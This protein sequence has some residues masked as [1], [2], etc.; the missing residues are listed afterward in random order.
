MVFPWGKFHTIPGGQDGAGTQG[1]MKC[2]SFL[3][4]KTFIA[5]FR[6]NPK[7]ELH[8]QCQSRKLQLLWADALF[9]LGNLMQH[10]PLESSAS[11]TVDLSLI[12]ELWG[13]GRSLSFHISHLTKCKVLMQHCGDGWQTAEGTGAECLGTAWNSVLYGKCRSASLNPPTLS[14]RLRDRAATWT[15][16]W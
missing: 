1:R 16:G 15:G 12:Q 6:V 4:I 9:M 5:S 2:P 14:L 8:S 7:S 3:Q 13:A 10:L 11:S